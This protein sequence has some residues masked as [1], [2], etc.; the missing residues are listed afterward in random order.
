MTMNQ[1]TIEDYLALP[2]RMVVTPDE[3]GFGVEIP[4][5]PGCYTHAELWGDIQAMVREAMA[6]W[7]GIM[8]ED[9]KPIPEPEPQPTQ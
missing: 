9:G 7:I 4:D 5:L 8:L 1:K 2:Y 3:E 6:L